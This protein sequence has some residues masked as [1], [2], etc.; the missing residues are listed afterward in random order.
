MAGHTITV[1]DNSFT[2]NLVSEALKQV[3]HFVFF[4]TLLGLVRDG[5]PI[6]GDDDVDVYVDVS[7]RHAALAALKRHGVHIELRLERNSTEHF[8]QFEG[9]ISGREVRLDL[10]FFSREDEHISEAWNFIGRP[11]HSQNHMR[12]PN[13]LIFPISQVEFQGNTVN[14]PSNAEGV[15]EF[16]YGSE[17]RTPKRKDRQYEMEIICGAPS[18]VKINYFVYLKRRVLSLGRSIKKRIRR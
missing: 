17:W 6:T 1:E 3:E 5:A 16:L 8:C 7:N 15:C 14:C 18:L 2:I 13:S 12:V 9:E 4:G 10:Y 11:E